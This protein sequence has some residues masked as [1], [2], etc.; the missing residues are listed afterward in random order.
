MLGSSVGKFQIPNR[1]GEEP[2]LGLVVNG[3]STY[4][5]QDLNENQ[6]EV[7]QFGA[8]SWQHSAGDFDVQTSLIARYSSLTFIPDTLGDLLF[9]GVAQHAYKQ[10]VAYA[11]Q[12]DGAYRLNAGHTIRAGLFLQTDHSISDTTSHV[13]LTNDLGMPVSEVPTSIIDNGAATEW[14]YSA[15]LQD[16]WKLDPSF[17][18]N[19]GVRIDRFTAYTSANQASPRNGT[20]VGVG[21]PQFGPRR[22]VFFGLSKS[23]GSGT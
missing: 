18:I 20:G 14:I 4:P 9:T 3:V 19:Y 2:A 12:S 23:L 15:Y 16:E 7:T 11:A 22:G 1:Y 5:S 10:N 8:L 13:L 17:T 6:R 21:A